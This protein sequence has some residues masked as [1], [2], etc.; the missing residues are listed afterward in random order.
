[1]FEWTHL[2]LFIHMKRSLRYMVT[3]FRNRATK[4]ADVPVFYY[5]WKYLVTLL[6]SETRNTSTCNY[7]SY[8]QR[9]LV[10][11]PSQNLSRDRESNI[12]ESTNSLFYDLQI[13]RK[14]LNLT[15]SNNKSHDF[16]YIWNRIIT[17]RENNQ[18]NHYS[19]TV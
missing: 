18:R 6:N 15:M 8:L 16:Q 13:V 11:E 19:I 9:H 7:N 4:Y 17:N 12:R 14:I 1:M 10:S 3:F 2:S 5:I